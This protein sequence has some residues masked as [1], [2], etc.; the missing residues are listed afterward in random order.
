MYFSIL[1][2]RGSAVYNK[3]LLEELV[4]YFPVTTIWVFEQVEKTLVCVCNGV[5]KTIQFERLQW[6]YYW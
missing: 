2:C 1:C 3:K 6:W 5:S 4:T